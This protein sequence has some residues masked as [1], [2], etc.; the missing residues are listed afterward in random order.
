MLD[1]TILSDFKQIKFLLRSNMHSM[2]LFC[3]IEHNKL[4]VIDATQKKQNDYKLL[5][6]LKNI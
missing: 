4:L 3:S 2:T 5:R 1:A 6:I